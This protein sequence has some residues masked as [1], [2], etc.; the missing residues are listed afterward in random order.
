MFKKKAITLDDTIKNEKLKEIQIL[1][2]SGN[3]RKAKAELASI[4]SS[5]LSKE[6]KNEFDKLIHVTSID[7]VGIY[8]AVAMLIIALYLLIDYSH[9]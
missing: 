6:E 2:K 7:K 8:V 4:D 5:K 3:F 1:Y 9:L